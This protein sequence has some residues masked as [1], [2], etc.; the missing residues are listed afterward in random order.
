VP[1]DL[2]PYAFRRIFAGS[3]ATPRSDVEAIV[4]CGGRQA[5]RSGAALGS[6]RSIE[7]RGDPLLTMRS[8]RQAVATDGNG[9]GLL[10]PV[11]RGGDLP[12]VPWVATTGL[13]KGSIVCS[14]IR[15]RTHTNLRRG[16]PCLLETWSSS[17]AVAPA[18]LSHS[19]AAGVVLV[20]P[21]LGPAGRRRVAEVPF[22]WSLSALLL[23][24]AFLGRFG[25]FPAP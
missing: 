20:T 10:V 11:S 9:F 15:Q 16:T 18:I 19:T 25:G 13:H 5:H 22:L 21:L 3:G 17:L 6:V 8:F 12:P 4:A 14:Q 24:D 1:S 7:V 23:I 2:C